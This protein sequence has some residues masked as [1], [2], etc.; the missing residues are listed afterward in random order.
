MEQVK[1][2][3]DASKLVHTLLDIGEEMLLS[4]A[5][6]FRVEDTVSHIGNAYGA[7]RVNIFVITSSIILTLTDA[8]GRDWTH[9]KRIEKPAGTDFA[10]LEK[11]NELSRDCCAE[12]LTLDELERCSGFAGWVDV[13]KGWNDPA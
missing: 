10:R 12:G 5:E 6:V 2:A 7:Q 9:T 1:V 3:I 13:C 11:L 8:E 4:G